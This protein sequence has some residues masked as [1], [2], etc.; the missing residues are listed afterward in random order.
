MDAQRV[1]IRTAGIIWMGPS[2]PGVVAVFLLYGER[3]S[4]EGG[5][6]KMGKAAGDRFSGL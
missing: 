6:R 1:S 5:D 2:L 4:A 3:L